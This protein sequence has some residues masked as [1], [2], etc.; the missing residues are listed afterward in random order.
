MD[1]VIT[2]CKEHKL[3][4]I[5]GVW[6][7]GIAASMAYNATKPGLRT[8]VKVR[9]GW[10]LRIRCAENTERTEGGSEGTRDGSC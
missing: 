7:S 10:V 6:V 1:G 8:S 3:R 2:W 9:R 5:G 4:A